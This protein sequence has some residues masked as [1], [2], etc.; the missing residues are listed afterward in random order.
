MKRMTSYILVALAGLTVCGLLILRHA[1][2]TA[3]LMPPTSD[4][5]APLARSRHAVDRGQ[6]DIQVDTRPDYSPEPESTKRLME[7][8]RQEELRQRPQEGRN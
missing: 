2:R 6:D 3:P 5:P 4:L 7:K 1:C 8:L